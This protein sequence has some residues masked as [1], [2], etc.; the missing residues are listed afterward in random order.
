M[1]AVSGP[2]LLFSGPE[3]PHLYLSLRNGSA[4][5]AQAG[6]KG[7]LCCV[8]RAQTFCSATS[9]VFGRLG[10]QSP[11][12]THHSLDHLM[13]IANPS[14]II[15]QMGQFLPS[16]SPSLSLVW[17][18]VICSDFSSAQK[19]ALTGSTCPWAPVTQS[20]VNG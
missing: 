10:G 20:Q 19:T 9:R 2:A 1:L 11:S 16:L 4:A 12:H 15:C 8:P 18:H 17:G 6:R 13:G 5:W 7:P 14:F 3:F